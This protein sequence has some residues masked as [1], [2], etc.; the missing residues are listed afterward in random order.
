M[1]CWLGTAALHCASIAREW[2]IEAPRSGFECLAAAASTPCCKMQQGR[3]RLLPMQ[4]RERLAATAVCRCAE[5]RGTG[6]R[7]RVLGVVCESF[8]CRTRAA[9]VNL[10][11]LWEVCLVFGLLDSVSVSRVVPALQMM[12]LCPTICTWRYLYLQHLLCALLLL[13]VGLPACCVNG[14]PSGSFRTRSTP[15]A[16]RITSLANCNSVPFSVR[17]RL[18]PPAE[19]TCRHNG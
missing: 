3:A 15:G 8:L 1:A 9:A 18:R 11:H 13:A 10:H 17:A 2:M 16:V 12:C 14:N 19:C 5:R 4:G 7:V 6:V